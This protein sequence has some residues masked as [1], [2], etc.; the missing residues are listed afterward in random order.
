MWFAI[1]FATFVGCVVYSKSE[2][3]HLV[4]VRSAVD[5]EHY[6][7]LRDR[8]Q[9]HEAADML[10]RAHR[11]LTELVA[12]LDVRAREGRVPADLAE[13]VATL[14]RRVRHT[15][16][17]IYELAPD[18]RTIAENQ[19]KGDRIFVCLRRDADGA[20][21]GSYDTLMYVLFHEL[22]HT[23]RREYDAENADGTT[24]HSAEFKRCEAY[25]YS[26]AD[27]TGLF[28]PADMPMRR[29]CGTVIPMTI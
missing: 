19:N 4:A 25:L 8:G 27:Q 29:H 3:R 2:F 28:K 17:N 6:Y 7:V 20:Q 24:D 5:D 16:I 21:I 14:L 15:G 13:N 10:A 1:A 18:A 11:T 22:A 12:D 23:M 26:I 9:Q